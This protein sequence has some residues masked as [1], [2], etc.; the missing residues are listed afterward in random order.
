MALQI[1]YTQTPVAC[2]L[3]TDLPTDHRPCTSPEQSGEGSL[4]RQPMCLRQKKYSQSVKDNLLES[5]IPTWALTISMYFRPISLQLEVG[6]KPHP[7]DVDGSATPAEGPWKS[8]ATPPSTEPQTFAFVISI[9]DRK[10][11]D[12]ITFS[13]TW[14]NAASLVVRKGAMLE[15]SFPPL[16]AHG[17]YGTGP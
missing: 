1:R 5:Q 2:T 8:I 7:K 14:V 10:R 12:C 4:Q 13:K 11:L 3:D 16:P 9:C 6:P 15:S 17:V